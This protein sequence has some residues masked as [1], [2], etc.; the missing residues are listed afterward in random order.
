[1]FL[2]GF[3]RGKLGQKAISV[4]GFL[5]FLF[6]PV[7]IQAETL[8]QIKDKV[9]QITDQRIALEKQI[10][11]YDDQLKFLGDK[12]TEYQK[13]RDDSQNRLLE[14]Q[15][16]LDVQNN[17]LSENLAVM[18]EE[19]QISF[20]E[21][22][23]SAKSF[24][25]FVDQN[26]YL[27]VNRQ[28]LKDASEKITELRDE[29]KIYQ[30]KLEKYGAI[31]NVF[32]AS[33][34]AQRAQ[35]NTELDAVKAEELKIRDQFAVRLS[36][37]SGSAYCRSDNKIVRAK[38]PVFTFPTDCGFISQGYGM[39]EFASL[40]RAYN[41]AIHNGVD[42]GIETGTE[43][44]SI[45]PGTVYAKGASPSGGWGNWVMVRQD[46]VKVTIG[47]TEQEFEFYALYGHL[48]AESTL[49]VGDRVTGSQVVGF[50][51]GTP[52]WAPHLHFSLFLST[53]NWSD[54]NTGAYPGNT[55]D[56]LDFMDIPISTNGTDWDVHYAH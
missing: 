20:F 26:E 4:L 42:V 8:D 29:Q 55:I 27:N 9:E 53:S 45:G 38:Y 15:R 47:N 41:G 37:F 46:K 34:D 43:V 1:M 3:K 24:S 35:K 19:G 40:D 50:S 56:P 6:Y 7:S 31:I 17:Y 44:R 25:E 28:K 22:L 23:F 21:R 30:A 10:Q 13:M 36:K 32:K 2:L 49:K 39:T 33:L 52:F 5:V 51:G 11:T 14:I 54:G 16:Q 48:V 12:I 18:Y